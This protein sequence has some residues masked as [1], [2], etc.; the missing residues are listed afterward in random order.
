MD[1]QKEV[2]KLL[3]EHGQP[4]RHNRHEAWRLNG[5]LVV[6]TNTRTDDRGWRNKLAEVRRCMRTPAVM[7]FGYPRC[8][9][10]DQ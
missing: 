7:A 9:G 4:E 5:H 10:K 6:I 8:N 2:R 1:A 3:K